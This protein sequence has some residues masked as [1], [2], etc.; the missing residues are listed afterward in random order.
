M[1]R[2]QEIKGN[3]RVNWW[4]WWENLW[5]Q[6]YLPLAFNYRIFAKIKLL[7]TKKSNAYIN[8]VTLF[9][10]R[11]KKM[12]CSVYL[13]VFSY[14]PIYK[15][16]QRRRRSCFPLICWEVRRHERKFSWEFYPNL[17]PY[18]LKNHR[19]YSGAMKNVFLILGRALSADCLSF[20][21]YTMILDSKFHLK[22]YNE[23]F[24]VYWSSWRVDG[25]YRKGQNT[26]NS[27]FKDDFE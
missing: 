23:S 7:R 2:I 20:L 4:A 26:S 25:E 14:S 10:M 6:C 12:K 8:V 13:I 18:L 21:Q 22:K 19:K 24:E 3:T 16:T 1:L 27:D 11:W 17:A 15:L 5:Q 9:Y